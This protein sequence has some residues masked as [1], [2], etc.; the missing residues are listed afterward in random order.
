[1][2]W[3][4]VFVFG[5]LAHSTKDGGTIPVVP[6]CWGSTGEGARASAGTGIVDM[7]IIVVFCVVDIGIIVLSFFR[8]PCC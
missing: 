4:E 8:E 2:S 1:M 6:W 7:E 5:R 3:S